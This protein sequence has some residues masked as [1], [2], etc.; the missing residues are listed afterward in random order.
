MGEVLPAFVGSSFL[1]TPDL[2][3]LTPSQDPHSHSCALEPVRDV[4][5]T[6][7]HLLFM[8][9]QGSVD[10]DGAKAPIVAE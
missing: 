1:T 7:G 3:S 4:R 5:Y 6:E 2:L 9:S 8:L 10:N